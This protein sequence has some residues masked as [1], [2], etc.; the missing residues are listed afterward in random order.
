MRA[1]YRKEGGIFFFVFLLFPFFLFGEEEPPRVVVTLKGVTF[2]T[3]DGGRFTL[4]RL[5]VTDRG[6]VVWEK[7]EGKGVVSGLKVVGKGEKG[8]GNFKTGR[9]TIWQGEGKDHL[10]REGKVEKGIWVQGEGRFY[11]E[12]VY[13]RSSRYRFSARKGSLSKDLDFVTL[14]GVRG[15]I[16]P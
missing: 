2:F 16:Q 11:G 1:E 12:G 9:F 8:E 15:V 10:G 14:E 6:K 4:E 13:G 3:V 7:G 5:V